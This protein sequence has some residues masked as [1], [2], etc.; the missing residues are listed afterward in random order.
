MLGTRRSRKIYEVW[1][2]QG[3]VYR[4]LHL[5]SGR[6][7]G[8]SIIKHFWLGLRQLQVICFDFLVWHLSFSHLLLRFLAL[9]E[10]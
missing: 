7:L 5:S 3:H 4:V 6:A 10:F 8:I 9:N 1:R 2:V